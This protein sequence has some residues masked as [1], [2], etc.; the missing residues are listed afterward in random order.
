M[1]RLQRSYSFNQKYQCKVSICGPAYDTN[2][3]LPYL[4]QRNIKL[5]IPP[6]RNRLHQRGYKGF[7]KK[8]Q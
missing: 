7:K 3:I 2:D 5:V 4:Y 6:E 1:C 8:R